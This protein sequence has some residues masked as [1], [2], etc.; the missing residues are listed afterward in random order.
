[1]LLPGRKAGLHGLAGP[2]AVLAPLPSGGQLLCAEQQG[3]LLVPGGGRRRAEP[4]LSAAALALLQPKRVVVELFPG[5]PL[6]QV[7]QLAQ[8]DDLRVVFNALAQIG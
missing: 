1:M 7:Q 8:H 4:E 3:R 5:E 2:I 6:Q